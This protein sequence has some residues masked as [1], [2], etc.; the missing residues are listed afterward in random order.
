MQV[1]HSARKMIVESRDHQPKKVAIA[2]LGVEGHFWQIRV[3]MLD[4]I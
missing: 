4:L 1:M 3:L 2:V